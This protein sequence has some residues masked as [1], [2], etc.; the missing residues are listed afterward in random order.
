M[1]PVP[2]AVAS[3]RKASSQLGIKVP[4]GKLVVFGSPDLFSNKNISSLGNVSLFFNTLN[5]MLEKDQLLIIPPRPVETYQLVISQDQLRRVG[6]LFL[7][8]PG[9][10]ALLG[11]VVYWVRQS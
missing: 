5:W 2:L 7:A 6:L 11:F 9:V 8:V 10:V 3:E 1:G 4:G